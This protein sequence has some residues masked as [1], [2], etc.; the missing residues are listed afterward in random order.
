MH[1]PDKL[2]HQL[3]LKIPVL[4]NYSGIRR[5][6]V[7]M[8]MRFSTDLPEVLLIERAEK[9]NDLWSGHLAMPGGRM[10]A[11]DASPRHTAERETSEEIGVQL[12]DSHYIGQLSDVEAEGVPLIISCFAYCM[13]GSPQ[14]NLNPLEV[15]DAFWFPLSHFLD[16]GNKMTVERQ[17]PNGCRAFPAVSVA[18]KSQPL[19][20]ITYKLL[21]DLHKHL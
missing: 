12:L 4:R 16:P 10:D 8:I 3:S 13:N 1:T 20:G 6:A 7:A 5:A 18:G 9:D 15:A 21:I 2:R 11:C 19:W 14:L 17:L